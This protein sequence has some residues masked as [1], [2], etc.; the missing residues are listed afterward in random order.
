[1][2]WLFLALF[3]L[4]VAVFTPICIGTTDPH[5]IHYKLFGVLRHHSAAYVSA[6]SDS[7]AP[8]AGILFAVRSKLR[9]QADDVEI[10]NMWHVH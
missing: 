6:P 3:L 1:M 9:S 4:V 2:H 10:S 8:H 5:E 7:I